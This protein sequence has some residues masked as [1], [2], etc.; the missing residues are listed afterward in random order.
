MHLFFFHYLDDDQRASLLS[1]VA[2]LL[3]RSVIALQD[4]SPRLAPFSASCILLIID[5]LFRYY[6]E[7]SAKY[8]LLIQDQLLDTTT[9]TTRQINYL[10]LLE[11]LYSNERKQANTKPK[12]FFYSLTENSV[13]SISSNN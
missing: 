12:I 13:Q 1:Q 5:Y 3:N 10:Q 2:G 7:T 8:L 6:D 4:Q 9:S 11:Q